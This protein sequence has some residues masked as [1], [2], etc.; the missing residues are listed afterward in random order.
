[1]KEINVTL[2][3]EDFKKMLKKI[4][5]HP[6]SK[7]IIDAIV[8]NLTQTSH[9]CTHLYKA[10]MGIDIIPKF[11]VGDKVIDKEINLGS[12]YRS[13]G[14]A[15]EELKNFLQSKGIKFYEYS[16]E[17]VKPKATDKIDNSPAVG[18]GNEK[19]SIDTNEPSSNG[20][21]TGD[22]MAKEEQGV[23]EGAKVDRQ[24][25]HITSSM[26]KKG[27]S[28]KD[29]ESIAWAHI[30]HP[31]NESADTYFESLDNMLERQLE[32]TMDLDAWVDNFQN[33]DPQKYH[34]FKNKTPEKKK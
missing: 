12:H 22:Y 28:K 4:V 2:S 9:G 18:T 14:E 6:N 29:A 25:K 13:P 5:V 17:R 3:E 1:V 11:K 30:K 10:F 27:K 19:P 21:N 7:L 23:E 24:A 16:L 26:M 20:K 34:Q 8:G 32:P 33:A 31:K 15:G